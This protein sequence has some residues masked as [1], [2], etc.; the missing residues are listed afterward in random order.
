MK[1]MGMYR[2]ATGT[3][4]TNAHRGRE[5]LRA[6]GIL[7]SRCGILVPQLPLKMM[8]ATNRECRFS[9]WFTLQLS[10]DQAPLIEHNNQTFT[11]R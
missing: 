2:L 7:R 8:L 9:P 11:G 4:A 1:L 5:I 3:A 10:F 6:K